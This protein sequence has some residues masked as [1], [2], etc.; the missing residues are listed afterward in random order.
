MT[1]QVEEDTEFTEKYRKRNTGI[2]SVIKPPCSLWLK[3]FVVVLMESGMSERKLQI[4]I[5]SDVV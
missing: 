5:V 2:G 1:H 4:D 3:N